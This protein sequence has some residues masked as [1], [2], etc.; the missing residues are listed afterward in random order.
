VADHHSEQEQLDALKRWWQENQNHVLTGLVLGVAI[1]GGWRWWEHYQTQRAEEASAV[2]AQLVEAGTARD[3]E[4]ID[5]LFQRLQQDYASTPYAA[6][7]ALVVAQA[8][9]AAGELAA[10]ETALQWAAGQTKDAEFAGVVRLR[11]ARVQFAGGKGEAALTTLAGVPAGSFVSLVEELKGD[12]ELALGRPEAARTA[13]QAALAAT[14]E[15]EGDRTVLQM[16]LDGL[17]PAPAVTP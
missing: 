17:A 11:L 14:P 7:G 16:K 13:W 2:H 3:Q 5:A 4:R 9:V 12:I 8:E 6:Q 10:A 15:G 1:V